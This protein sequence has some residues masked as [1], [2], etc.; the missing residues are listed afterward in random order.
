MALDLAS[1]AFAFCVL[2]FY[3]AIPEQAQDKAYRSPFAGIAEGFDFL[4]KEKGRSEE[5][6]V[7]KEC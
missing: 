3:I 2:Q 7:G 5:R 1:F 6:R 4:K